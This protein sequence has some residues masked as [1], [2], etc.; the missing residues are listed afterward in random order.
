MSN[1]PKGVRV[2]KMMEDWSADIRSINMSA[3]VAPSALPEG[4]FG[5]LLQRSEGGG[6]VSSCLCGLAAV[7]PVA[8]LTGMAAA[9]AISSTK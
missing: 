1:T 8:V 3:A 2:R 7:V 6:I 4:M 5:G 9:R